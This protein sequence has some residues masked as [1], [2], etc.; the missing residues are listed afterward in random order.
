[1]WMELRDVHR[2][3]GHCPLPTSE[4]EAQILHPAVAP[5]VFSG[6]SLRKVKS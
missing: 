5:R 3:S 2:H 6:V 1:M 4:R